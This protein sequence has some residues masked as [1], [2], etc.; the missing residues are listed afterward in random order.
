MVDGKAG[1]VQ[2]EQKCE[3]LKESLEEREAMIV[4]L[5][6]DLERSKDKD[7]MVHVQLSKVV[8]QSERTAGERDSLVKMVKRF[9]PVVCLTLYDIIEW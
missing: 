9:W 2:L 4:H 7:A 5:Q 6:T 3:V 8:V 1:T